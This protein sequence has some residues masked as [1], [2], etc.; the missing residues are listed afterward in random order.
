MKRAVAAAV[1]LAVAGLVQAAP[2]NYKIDPQH[3]Y[4][5]FEADHQG[6]L[7]IWRGKI[8]SSSGKVVYD[9]EARTG[10]V[11]VTMDMSTIDFG[12]DKMNTHAMSADMFDVAKFPTATFTGELTSFKGDSPTEVWGSLTLHGV[13]KPVKLNINSFLCK[14]VTIPP[15]RETC[16]ADASGTI[17]REDF[18]VGYGK[19]L[20]F[21]M[22]V[23]LLITIEAQR[24]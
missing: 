17:N 23:K 10:T 19:A 7:S 18:G 22:D 6:G 4:P 5:A 12:L 24:S 15:S 20:G 21:K 9:R 13:T 11:E 3:T 14:P 1:F 8:R 2:V 16:G